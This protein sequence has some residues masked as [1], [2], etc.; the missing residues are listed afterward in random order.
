MI[1][2]GFLQQNAFDDIDK[3]CSTDKQIAILELIM[4]FYKRA[5]A[6]IKAGAPL[7]QVSTLPVC[8]E[9]VRIKMVY[10]NE[11]MDKINEIKNHLDSQ[12]SEVERMYR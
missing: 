3:Y 2:N 1:K 12:M 10:K 5:L 4:T 7:T 6:C 9:I 8:D 11:E